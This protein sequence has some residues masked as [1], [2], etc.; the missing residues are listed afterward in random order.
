MNNNNPIE[1]EVVPTQAVAVRPK[2]E[3][4]S[5]SDLE[6]AF[7]LAVKQRELL[8]DYIKKQLEPGKHFY[9]VK[10]SQKKSLTKEGAEIILLPH[11]LCPDYEIVSGPSEPP[12]GDKAY[13]VT[14]KCSLRHKGDPNS[15]VGSGIGSAGSHKGTWKDGKWVYVPRQSDRYLCH[16][17]TLKMAEKSAMIAATINSTAASEFFTQDM[18]PD[19]KPPPEKPPPKKASEKD[20][21]VLTK[22]VPPTPQRLLD[23]FIKNLDENQL[24]EKATQFLIDLSWLFPD[25]PLEKLG[26]AYVPNSKDQYV[27]FIHKLTEWSV[28]GKAEKPYPPN[29]PTETKPPAE[30]KPIEVPRDPVPDCNSPDA[31]WRSFPVPFGRHAGTK[32]ADLDK[33][34]LY[35]FWANF[36][37]KDFFLGADG[38]TKRRTPQ[39]IAADQQFRDMLDAAGAHYQFEKKD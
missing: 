22:K 3:V 25:A 31:P 23:K 27:A 11:G 35:G 17:A 6:Q 10:G 2:G 9:D 32:L 20:E 14:V 13:Q 5:I 34:A 30:T 16:N 36:E 37:V 29:Q 24:R 26:F 21:I 38:Q 19:A 28:T 39:K 15:F 18:E 12:E 4:Q 8:A 7:A 33:A 1:A